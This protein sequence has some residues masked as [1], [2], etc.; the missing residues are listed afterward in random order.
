MLPLARTARAGSPGPQANTA[1]VR[2]AGQLDRN[3]GN[4]TASA[5]GTRPGFAIIWL[6]NTLGKAAPHVTSIVVPI[7][8]EQRSGLFPSLFPASGTP[9]TAPS[10]RRAAAKQETPS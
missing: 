9:H 1:A 6:P 3:N 5:T 4:N 7:V 10:C 2:D 8:D